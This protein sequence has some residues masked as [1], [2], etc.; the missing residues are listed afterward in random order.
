M[1]REV[2]SMIGSG[3]LHFTRGILP[4]GQRGDEPT[5]E[6]IRIGTQVMIGNPEDL[7]SVDAW[8]C[9]GV[10]V[11]TL[12]PTQLVGPH[13]NPLPR[14]RAIEITVNGNA[15]GQDLYIGPR[16]NFN[17]TVEGLPLEGGSEGIN[18]AKRVKLPLLHNNEVWALSV[19]GVLDVRILIY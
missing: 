16:E 19:G 15:A 14:C 1:S 17:F 13:T 4:V 10:T 5:G 11:G 9:S 2:A 18:G 12:V 7:T 3:T 6:G 8:T